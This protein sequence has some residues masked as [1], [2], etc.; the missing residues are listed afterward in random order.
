MKTNP[1]KLASSTSD[2]PKK[3]RD[4]VPQVHRD[5]AAGGAGEAESTHFVLRL[6]VAGQMPKSVHAIANIKLIC[7]EY[8]QGRYEL[9][10]I[11][12]YQQPQLAQSEQIIVLPTL[13][14]QLPSPLQRVIGDLSNT[15]R[16]LRG[17]D[18]QKRIQF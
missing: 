12:L 17:L 14:K 18:L 4:V 8:L 3:H 2:L 6:Y 1:A 15:E 7:E 9:E 5:A 11:D 10:V 16:V 13:I